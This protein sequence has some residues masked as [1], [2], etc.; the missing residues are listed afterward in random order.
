MDSF[1]DTASEVSSEDVPVN[2]ELHKRL[3]TLQ[4]DYNLLL[5]ICSKGPTWK[6]AEQAKYLLQAAQPFAKLL[7]GSAVD[8]QGSFQNPWSAEIFLLSAGVPADAVGC[9]GQYKPPW[10]RRH[11]SL[12]ERPITREVA[13]HILSGVVCLLEQDFHPAYLLC[14]QSLQALDCQELRVCPAITLVSWFL[15]LTGKRRHLRELRAATIATVAHTRSLT[16]PTSYGDLFN[17]VKDLSQT[18]NLV[19]L[20]CNGKKLDACTIL[21]SQV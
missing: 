5:T 20:V 10:C 3:Q 21:E 13:K 18:H 16:T 1:E 8:L 2:T 12:P 9:L 15:Q 19:Y 11:A 7:R 6:V 17:A 4:H 14:E